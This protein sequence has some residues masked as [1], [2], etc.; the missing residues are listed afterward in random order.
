MT[1]YALS[2][3]NGDTGRFFFFAFLKYRLKN[4]FILLNGEN[5]SLIK[6]FYLRRLNS[7]L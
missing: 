2:V 6:G 4:K 3:K 1:Y 5:L 7:F